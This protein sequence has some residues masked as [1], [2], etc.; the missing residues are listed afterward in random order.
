[1]TIDAGAQWT[2]AGSNSLSGITLTDL[3]TLT[4]T[5]TL[6]GTGS[7]VVDPATLFNSGSIGVAVT[8]FGGSYLDNT[9]PHGRC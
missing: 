4:N 3:G 5:G 9:T 8:L 7:L 2:L 6:T 1:M